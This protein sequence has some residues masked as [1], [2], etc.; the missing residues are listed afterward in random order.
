MPE[1]FIWACITF[2][3]WTSPLVLIMIVGYAL[4]KT[5][6]GTIEEKDLL[7]IGAGSYMACLKAT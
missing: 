5:P 3:G 4:A 7:L 1:A 6:P 2:C